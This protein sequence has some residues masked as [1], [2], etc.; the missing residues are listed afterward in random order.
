ML[1]KMPQTRGHNDYHGADGSRRDVCNYPSNSE[2]EIQSKEKYQVNHD[3]RLANQ[4]EILVGADSYP[5]CNFI[6][7]I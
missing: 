3:I 1:P 2:E 7:G 5:V 4:P 6:L